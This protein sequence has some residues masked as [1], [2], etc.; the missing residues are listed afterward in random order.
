MRLDRDGEKAKE[1]QIEPEEQ[2][3][4]GYIPTISSDNHAY[5]LLPGW[6]GAWMAGPSHW[7]GKRVALIARWTAERAGLEILLV[8]LLSWLIVCPAPRQCV[9]VIMLPTYQKSN[10]PHEAG[11]LAIG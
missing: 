2:R 11:G 9:R 6:Q 3:L 1:T 5:K 4:A 7:A 8:P 10:F